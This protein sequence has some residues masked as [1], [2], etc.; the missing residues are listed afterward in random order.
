MSQKASLSYRPDIDGLR[1]VAVLP[2]LLFHAGL[3]CSGGFVGVDVFF[4]ISGFLIGSLIIKESDSGTFRYLNFWERRIRRLFPA[5][6]LVVLTTL[7]A[8]AIWMVPEHFK[9]FGQSLIAQPLLISN[10][11]FWRQT[12]YFETASEFQ[13]LLHTWSL[14]VEEQF[15]L[16]FPPLILFLTRRGKGFA[17]KGL[18]ALSIVSL[19]WSIYGTR[20]YPS[21]SFF[22]IASRIWELALGVLLA[23]LPAAKSKSPLRNEILAWV[24]LSMILLAV[25]SFS[26]N[27]PFP[28]SAALIPC[29]GTALVIYGNSNNT[30]N[31]GKLLS[32]KPLLFIGKI[33][34]PLYLWHWPVI[35]FLKYVFVIDLTP[36]QMTGAL[37][38]SVVLAWV[39]WK[40]IENPIRSKQRLATRNSLFVAA[41]VVSALMI[42]VGAYIYRKDGFPNRFSP[43]VLKFAP[44]AHP[45]NE[46]SG[47][48]E[49]IEAGTLPAVGA[50]DEAEPA[51]K[52]LVWGDSHAMAMLPILDD[53]G[54]ELGVTV[55]AATKPGSPP[56]PHTF[57]RRED[58]EH[59]P[60]HL[61][62]PVLRFIRE[63]D[64]KEVLLIAR[65]SIYLF[66][67][68]SGDL[69]YL[70]SD[71]E[72]RSSNAGQARKVFVKNLKQAI[73]DWEEQ[74]VK[75]WVMKDVVTQ[76]TDVPSALAQLASRG[77]DLNSFARRASEV[78][79]ENAEINQIIH[80]AT[81]ESS[82][83]VI[84][85]LPLFLDK[86]GKYLVV[87]DGH[88]LYGDRHHLSP[89]GSRI[90]RP[91]MEPIFKEAC[92]VR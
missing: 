24:G 6:A 56:V 91:I 78:E 48:P 85:P 8:S 5:M 67:G 82:A 54:K 36:M 28:G 64:I 11:Y 16:V 59:R 66:G 89:Y 71:S 3:G 25:F 50:S 30:T 42:G 29:L 40:Y 19:A 34:Y 75:V 57:R 61:G 69:R 13:P 10:F 77:R 65:W 9:S 7:A 62:K 60:P 44:E 74:G 23:L 1:A 14:A 79:A 63:N 58:N 49:L 12:G 21:F 90:L 22:L 46:L 39:S 26:I 87:K 35:V 55:Y 53:L 31:C 52:I 32:L 33:S 37:G 72:T 76:I 41:A 73:S 68:D 80:E 43:D 84:D 15:Y 18:L 83:K 51:G 88:T 17:F 38:F 45:Y 20:Y 86:S 92:T 81:E 4:V 27:T 47:L 70:L 2:V